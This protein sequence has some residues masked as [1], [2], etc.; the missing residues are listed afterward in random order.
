M[1]HEE[2]NAESQTDMRVVSI[3]HLTLG[4]KVNKWVNISQNAE[5]SLKGCIHFGPKGWVLHRLSHRNPTVKSVNQVTVL[6]QQSSLGMS[7][8]RRSPAWI[9]SPVQALKL[10][11]LDEGCREGPAAHTGVLRQWMVMCCTASVLKRWTKF[12]WIRP[13]PISG[14]EASVFSIDWLINL[15]SWRI[16]VSQILII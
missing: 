14:Y 1:F 4:K 15:S 13:T 2:G 7:G 9:F 8:S 10:T 3:F 11:A 6:T 5:L 12:I 16:C